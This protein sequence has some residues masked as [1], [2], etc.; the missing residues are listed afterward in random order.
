MKVGILSAYVIFMIISL[1]VNFVM[2]Y[3]VLAKKT[4]LRNGP[5]VTYTVIHSFVHLFFAIMLTRIAI[6]SGFKA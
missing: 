3:L 5:Y 2:A 6:K 4:T 1:L